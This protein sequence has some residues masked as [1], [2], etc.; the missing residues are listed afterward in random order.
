MELKEFLDELRSDIYLEVNER[1]A[2]GDTSYPYAEMVFTEHVMQHM[3]D[4]GMTFEPHVLHHSS[5]LGNANLRLSGFAVSDDEDQLDLFVTLFF[6]D[7]DISPIAESDT[8]NAAGQ[9]IRFFER[10]ID[11]K[12]ADQLDPS[13]EAFELVARISKIYPQLESLRI[14]V[15]TDRKARVK[16]FASRSVGSLLVRLEVMDIE[17]LFNHCAAGRPRDELIVNFQELSGASLPCIYV[18]NTDGAD[19]DYALTVI[20]GETLRAVYERYGARLLEANVRSFLSYAGKV[21]KGIRETLRNAPSRFMAYNNGIVIVADQVGLED[22]KESGAALSWLKG[23]QIVN[24]GQ[25]TATIYFTKRR[26][27][28]TDLSKVRI[29]AKIIVLN[30]GTDEESEELIA[31]ISRFANTQ[32]AVRTSDLSANKPLHVEL[33]RLAN[34]IFC[35]DGIGRWFYERAAGSYNTYLQREV[36]TSK[37]KRLREIVIPPKRK[38]TKT[39]VA[40]YVNAWGQKPYFV[41][42]GA[43]K[44][45]EKYMDEVSNVDIKTIDAT[46][47]KHLIAK[48]IIFKKC[49]EIVRPLVKA[50]QANVCAYLVSL[51]SLKMGQ[52]VN[53]DRIWLAQDLS[54]E[55]KSHI[56]VWAVEVNAALEATANGRMISEWAKKLEC[57][58]AISAYSYSK[59]PES[60]PEFKR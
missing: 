36:S 56:R 16:Q 22:L 2:A 13:G 50:F 3:F 34:S 21:N 28:E 30:R 5:R 20:P 4:V 9:C 60:L 46:F 24:G 42:L 47:Y 26:D 25:T 12:L 43:Q 45:F 29:P 40:K 48:A 38:I 7:E 32:N 18:P 51:M 41:S 52:L 6:D 15:L 49:N 11:G 31:S 59:F 37:Q 35:P 1:L 33:E 8:K 44:N 14:Y 10:S 53:L 23:M 39:D 54:D 19:Y 57:W 27:P 17:R 58:E 55:L